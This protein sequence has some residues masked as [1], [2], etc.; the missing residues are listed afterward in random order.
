MASRR[1]QPTSKTA[2]RQRPKAAVPQQCN[3]FVSKYMYNKIKVGLLTSRVSPLVPHVGLD[4][5]LLSFV[6]Q[7]EAAVDDLA[8]DGDAA[9]DHG[10]ILAAQVVA[11]V[12]V[13]AVTQASRVESAT[14]SSASA[15]AAA[16]AFAAFGT[17]AAAG[18]S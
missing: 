16:A 2:G 5:P 11:L 8:V 7:R 17:A 15:P 6:V 9:A 10:A 1:V 18:A 3:S 13:A 12:S 4:D 14:M